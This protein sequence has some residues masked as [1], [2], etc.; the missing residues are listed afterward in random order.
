MRIPPCVPNTGLPCPCPHACHAQVF[1]TSKVSPY[2]Q[3]EALARPACR[4][5]LR[6][7][8]TDYVD[9]VLVHW[10]GA[11]KTP[12][13]SEANARLRQETWRVLEE[14]HRHVCTAS[15]PGPEGARQGL[16]TRMMI[17]S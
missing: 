9:L 7:L 15:G 1:I 10:P 8:G 2:E 14:F 11:S 16:S 17:L 3:G 12:P 4:D 13:G 6:R 5:I